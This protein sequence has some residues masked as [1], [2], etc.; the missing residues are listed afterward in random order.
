MRHVILSAIL[1][2]LAACGGDDPMMPVEGTEASELETIQQAVPVAECA[3]FMSESIDFPTR[4]ESEAAC[5]GMEQ[6][7]AR[8]DAQIDCIQEASDTIPAVERYLECEIAVLQTYLTC[9]E[10]VD[11]C[12]RLALNGCV[13]PRARDILP[14]G[15]MVFGEVATA[16]T[17]CQ[18]L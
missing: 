5:L 13:I 10:A 1:L 3:C 11:G 14:C 2:S 4:Y 15:D 9:L 8:T 7:P 6:P 16:L 17:A 12:D 18:R